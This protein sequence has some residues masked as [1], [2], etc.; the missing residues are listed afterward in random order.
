MAVMPWLVRAFRWLPATP[1]QAEPTSTPATRWAAATDCLTA[2]MVRS[3]LTTTPL[4]RP[5]EGTVPSPMMSSTP[6]E[7][8]S[9]ITVQIFV[10]PMS[11]PTMIRSS[12]MR[13]AHSPGVD[14]DAAAAVADESR[15]LLAQGLRTRCEKLAVGQL[16]LESFW[17]VAYHLDAEGPQE[18][19]ELERLGDPWLAP[20]LQAGQPLGLRGRRAE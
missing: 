19:Q 15:P 10:V 14:R 17:R 7:A 2:A 13:L 8:T 9:P 6:S 1:T 18:P 20:A 5:S 16:N 11:R 3:R 12:L 4:R